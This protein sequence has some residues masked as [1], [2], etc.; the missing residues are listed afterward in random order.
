MQGRGPKRPRRIL[1]L[2]VGGTH[3]KV[4]F[5]HRPPESRI[6]SGSKMTPARMMKG[7][8]PLLRGQRFDAVSIGY[9]GLVVHGRIVREPHNLGAGWVGYDF[10]K[11][12]RRPTRIV[13]DAA[14][15]ALGSYRG[16]RMLFLGLGTGLGSA[17][18]VD[19][20][21]EP[22][23]LAHLM[24]KKGKTYEEYVGESGLKRLGRKKWSKEVFAVVEALS[25]ALEPDYVVLGGGNT[26]KL[27]ELPPHCERGDNRNAIEGGV[28]VWAEERTPPPR[29][30][31]RAKLLR[32]PLRG[33]KS[34]GSRAI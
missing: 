15:Q 4:G 17:M 10:E 24:Y 22:M 30:A 23:E 28:R 21:L 13:N 34:R 2:D 14:M 29:G 32:G 8:A 1:I 7:L 11:G 25:S 19:G 5:S 18:I 12:F 26:R 3:I 16:G 27:R 9:P 6:P 33:P 31:T 20:Q